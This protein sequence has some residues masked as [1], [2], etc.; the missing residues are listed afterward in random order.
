MHRL[1]SLRFEPESAAGVGEHGAGA[2]DAIGNVD[3]RQ[4]GDARQDFRLMGHCKRTAHRHQ[5]VDD[6]YRRRGDRDDRRRA[7][8]GAEGECNERGVGVVQRAIEGQAIGHP[9]G[10]AGPDIGAK[11]ARNRFRRKADLVA[12]PKCGKCQAVERQHRDKWWKRV[13]GQWCEDRDRLDEVAGEAPDEVG[14]TEQR[15]GEIEHRNT[16]GRQAVVVRRFRRAQV[17]R[18]RVA[19]RRPVVQPITFGNG[20]PSPAHPCPTLLWDGINPKGLTQGQTDEVCSVLSIFLRQEVGDGEVA[21]AGVVVEGQDSG[22][23]S[24]FR[25][26]HLDRRKGRAGRDSNQNSLFPSGPAGHFS[27]VF[28]V[29]IDNSVQNGRVEDAWHEIGAQPLDR[30]WAG[31]AAAQDRR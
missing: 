26:L 21:L 22:I 17:E 2:G 9:Q 15:R 11:T 4:K 27:R 19:N 10:A 18:Q 16:Q 5:R 30:V 25:K 6:G 20:E 24:Q 12:E 31:L 13:A 23:F 7:K 3:D 14:R 8:P 28:G 1:A 29:D